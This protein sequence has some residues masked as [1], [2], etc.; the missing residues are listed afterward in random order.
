[1]L[2][3]PSSVAKRAMEIFFFTMEELTMNFLSISATSKGYTSVLW[4]AGLNMLMLYVCVYMDV[5]PLSS[6]SSDRKLVIVHLH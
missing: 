2:A 6:M 1:M 4:S 5:R 3:N